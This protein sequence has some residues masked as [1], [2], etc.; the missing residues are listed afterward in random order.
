M[1]MDMGQGSGEDTIQPAYDAREWSI[2]GEDE[3]V[4]RSRVSWSLAES[5]L[6]RGDCVMRDLGTNYEIQSTYPDY[7]AH[8][9]RT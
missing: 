3:E 9:T 4:D 7:N 5:Q 6:A 1:D 8:R 2:W